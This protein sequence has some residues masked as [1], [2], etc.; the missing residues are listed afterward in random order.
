MDPVVSEVEESPL[1]SVRR[2]LAEDRVWRRRCRSV[3]LE[4]VMASQ[5]KERSMCRSETTKSDL[6]LERSTVESRRKEEE[7]DAL[8]RAM[9]KI[10]KAAL[11][12]DRSFEANA[13]CLDEFETSKLSHEIFGH[14]A[15]RLVSS[16]RGGSR[17]SRAELQALCLVFDPDFSGFVDGRDF[18]RHFSKCGMEARAKETRFRLDHNE[19]RQRWQ[20]EITNQKTLKRRVFLK[21]GNKQ[22]KATDEDAAA[23]EKPLARRS[24]KKAYS[25]ADETAAWKK[26]A[27]AAS[28]R[29]AE[30]DATARR[31]FEGSKLT[32]EDLRTQLKRSYSVTLTKA[33]AQALC[34]RCDKDNSG[35]VDGAE[36][37]YAWS[38]VLE[39]NRAATQKNEAL[40]EQ[41][42]T[43][44]LTSTKLQQQRS[45][46]HQRSSRGLADLTPQTADRPASVDLK[47]STF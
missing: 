27:G 34:D 7:G 13:R 19:R 33:E 22:K 23:R 39:D 11:F 8:S 18:A 10:T 31:S 29:G 3:A 4:P 16:C 20:Q 45:F 5:Y 30:N 44:L 15:R 28:N 6:F 21:G 14:M 38:K 12:F 47:T 2:S 43:S 1:A 37:Q 24:K 9:G 46:R 35:L 41:H 26:L 25:A 32:T 17:L 36:F 40:A 42:R